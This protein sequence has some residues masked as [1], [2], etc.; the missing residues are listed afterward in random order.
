MDIPLNLA[1]TLTYQNAVVVF[2][3]WFQFAPG[4]RILNR[5]VCSRMLLWCRA[6]TGTVRVNGESFT[7]RADDYLVLPWRHEVLYEADASDPYFVG[8]IHVIPDHDPAHRVEFQLAHTFGD[9]LEKVAWR[10]DS[11]QPDADEVIRGSFAWAEPLR[12]I[13]TYTVERYAQAPPVEGPMRDLARLLLSEVASAV[14]Q[15]RAGTTEPPTSLHRMQEFIRDHLPDRLT[16]DDIA[17]AGGCSPA[18]VHRMFRAHLGE[19]PY[20]YVVK[21]RV[22]TARQLLCTTRRPVAE[23]AALVGFNDPYHFSRVFKNATGLSPQ[24]FRNSV[25]QI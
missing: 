19:T 20:G 23:V 22:K 11:S 14:T 3:N 2:A 10:R 18:T 13:A 15:R 21:L 7:M 8:G 5:C 25:P 24:H 1:S 9:H 12:L 17:G 6:G 16:V 4:E